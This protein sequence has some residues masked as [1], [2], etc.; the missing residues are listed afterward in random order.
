MESV[1]R[2]TQD[3]L[4]IHKPN[5]FFLLTFLLFAT[6]GSIVAASQDRKPASVSRLSLSSTSS[7]MT[8]NVDL[9]QTISITTYTPTST[10]NTPSPEYTLTPILTPSPTPELIGL[11]GFPAGINPLTGLPV[12]DPK[13]LNR[14]PVMIKVSNYPRYGRPH[15]GLSAA[16]IVFEYYIGEEMNRFLA[17]YYGQDSSKVGPIRSG[18]LVD[19]QL[20]NLFQG[21]LVYGSADPQVN[22]FLLHG[23]NDRA[24]TFSQPGCPPVC[25][26]DTHSVAGVFADSAGIT[27][28][29][30][31]NKIDNSRPDLTGMVFSPQVPCSTYSATKIGVEYSKIDRGEWYYDAKTHLYNHWLEDLDA[32]DKLIMVPLTDRNNNK[33]ISFA[34][35]IILST[36][37]IEYAPTLNNIIV[38][39]NNL[40][41]DAY[42]FRDGVMI[43][44]KW[45]VL[46]P[47]R[48]IEF[49][50]QGGLPMALKPGN[51]WIILTGDQSTIQQPSLG[52]WEIHFDLP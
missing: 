46:D 28:Y 45:R 33:P 38:R 6:A 11:K 26:F 23:L 44:G 35:V 51:T 7:V 17:L 40:G 21:I 37:Y 48:P 34:N 14:R 42:F 15:A 12:S 30:N 32:N 3:S 27:T 24:V 22:L 2:K 13:I 39:E 43:E 16:D 19:T 20:V 49:L 10:R 18:R 5:R 1:K 52:Q 9:T 25:G 50:D 8:K 36:T 4:S 29:A 47:Y 41:K 31:N